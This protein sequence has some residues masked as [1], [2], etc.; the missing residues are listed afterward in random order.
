MSGFNGRAFLLAVQELDTARRQLFDQ[1]GTRPSGR[2]SFVEQLADEAMRR[3]A[4]AAEGED[5]SH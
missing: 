3:L 1:H 4:G 5:G 2:L